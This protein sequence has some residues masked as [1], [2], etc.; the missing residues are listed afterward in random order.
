MKR[1]R[2]EERGGKAIGN[3]IACMISHNIFAMMMLLII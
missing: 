2:G 1:W 3:N